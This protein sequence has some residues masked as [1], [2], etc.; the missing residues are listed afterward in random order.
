MN[1][2]RRPRASSFRDS[3]LLNSGGGYCRESE[4]GNV[5]SSAIISYGNGVNAAAASS[6]HRDRLHTCVGRPCPFVSASGTIFMVS[7][8]RRGTTA[9]TTHLARRDRAYDAYDI[10]T[11]PTPSAGAL[12]DAV[13]HCCRTN[14]GRTYDNDLLT[15]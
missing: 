13:S 15:A 4:S 6:D 12:C 8:K 14:G 11:K 1:V 3:F 9:I 2:V 10:T 7:G 5:S